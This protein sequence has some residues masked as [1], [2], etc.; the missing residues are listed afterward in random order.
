[1]SQIIPDT[2]NIINSGVVRR[3]GLIVSAVNK[4][5]LVLPS[6]DTD[7]RSGQLP[8]QEPNSVCRGNA[9]PAGSLATTGRDEP[10]RD[11]VRHL[12]LELARR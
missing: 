5:A 10:R 12:G 11:A 6:F 9:Q 1:M 7:P 3:L 4:A 2:S 8:G